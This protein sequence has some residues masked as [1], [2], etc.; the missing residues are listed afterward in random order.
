ML[1]QDGSG[2]E[3]LTV[4]EMYSA[5]RLAIAGGVAGRDLME[6]AG[7]A[8]ADSVLLYESSRA[9]AV[10]VLCGPGNN[11]GD[12]FVVARRLKAAGRAVRLALLGDRSALTG[13]AAAAAADWD[14][15]IE[16]LDPAGLEDVALVVDAL[17][18]AGLNRPLDGLSAAMVEAVERAGLPVL[19]VDVPSGLA[20][21]RG[22]APDGPAFRADRT[23]TFFRKK[24]AHLIVPARFFC[25]D[26]QVAQIGIPESVLQEI[27]PRLFENSPA[28]WL[29]GFPWRPAEAH[30]YQAG[31]ALISGGT[32]MTGAAQLASRAALRIGAGLVSLACSPASLPIYALANPSV[33]TLAVGAAA[34]FVAAL[35]DPRRNAVLV[36]PG[37]GVGADTRERAIAA[38]EAGRSLVLDADA[39]T[40]F[41]G[42]TEELFK[43]TAASAGETVLTPHDGEFRRLFPG[44]A[45]DPLE[46]ARVAAAQSGAIVVLKGP[47]TV[48]AAPD[49]RASING[50]APPWLATAGTG[51]VLSGMIVGLLAQGMPAFLAAG[52]AVWIH[53]QAAFAF[54]PGMIS[55]DLPDALPKVLARL[56]DE[57]GR[58]VDYRKIVNNFR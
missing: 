52:A 38:L 34:D 56:S 32:E 9:G 23:V 43:L 36:G 15:E 44:I 17:F 19:A 50:S 24:P 41:E 49:R 31:H 53:A 4:E 13:D 11:G 58:A 30:K 16:V 12:G 33:I 18:G 54:G 37:N 28:L 10:L 40:V 3:I 14:G 48:V 6:A 29:A 21:D 27:S 45:G 42:R 5:D 35:A 46:R 22:D 26:V 47:D 2:A 51:D 1:S 25:G 55:E 39:L 20:G 7:T 8:V 57:A